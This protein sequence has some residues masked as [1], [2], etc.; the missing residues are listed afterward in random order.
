[1]FLGIGSFSF[2]LIATA[3]GA[4]GE[5]P[6]IEVLENPKIYLASEIYTSDQE[7]LGKYY[8][9]NRSFIEYDQLPQHL[10]DALIATEDIRFSEHAG[11][12]A[13]ALVRVL[14]KT[15]IFMQNT[16]GGST[17]TQQLAKNLFHERPQSVVERIKQKLKEWIISVRLEER[18]TK[19]EIIIMYFNT[20]E[21]G[22]HAFGIKSAART[23]FNKIPDS[24]S[25]D[26]SA[27]LIGML[28]ATT[29]YNPK[30][31][32]ENSKRRRN[33]VIGQMGKY[34]Y[35]SSEEADSIK[36]LEIKLDYI[37]IDHNEGLAPYF[38]EFLRAELKEWCKTTEKV[39][40]GNYNLYE[41]GL[42]IYTTI[43]SKMQRYAE[44]AVAEHMPKIQAKFFKHWDG[45]ENAPFTHVTEKQINRIFKLAMRWSDRYARLHAANVP[46]DSIEFIFNTP[47]D[48]TIFTWDGDKDTVMSPMDSIWY[49]KHFL[50]TGFAVM[51]PGTGFI[52]AWVGGIDHRYFKYDHV[53]IKAKRQV[54][55]TFKP[56][57]YSVAIME[58][59]SP[60]IEFP[61]MSPRFEKDEWGISKDWVPRNFDGK[62]EGMSTLQNGLAH[63]I[64]AIAAHVMFQIKPQNV[65]D[66]VRKMGISSPIDP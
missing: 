52:R 32:P 2:L 12:D 44:E 49:H 7:L 6:L 17:I 13:L 16:G 38:R 53:N 41:D 18:Y 51:D 61:M 35:L 26:E 11:I 58:G 10:V 15:V 3:N 40:G 59:W 56:F 64:N 29:Y 20:V 21:F 55:S 65:I 39:G 37:K 31:N 27:I 43:H 63:S 5:L 33:I 24:L 47:I 36:N 19:E 9:Q 54:G 45:R 46:K 42:K 8:R 1:M 48:M 25:V 50:H 4:F 57:V 62:N 28:K 23:F 14:I 30:R 60:C 34:G 66:L 22:S